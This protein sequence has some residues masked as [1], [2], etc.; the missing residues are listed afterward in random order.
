MYPKKTQNKRAC[1]FPICNSRL[2]L[3]VI[4]C[5][6]HKMLLPDTKTHAS[7]SKDVVSRSPIFPAAFSWSHV[8]DQCRCNEAVLFPFWSQPFLQEHDEFNVANF[9]VEKGVRFIFPIVFPLL[10]EP[11]Q[12]CCVL[13]VNSVIEI[14]IKKKCEPLHNF[15]NRITLANHCPL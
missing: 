2:L 9:L 8:S 1:V 13:F 7:S 3:I 12:T 11:L 14:I 10:A 15:L 4:L 5:S 6:H